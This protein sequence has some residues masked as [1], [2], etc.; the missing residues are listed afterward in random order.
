MIGRLAKELKGSAWRGGI[1]ASEKARF[2]R[3]YAKGRTTRAM[4]SAPDYIQKSKV[5]QFAAKRPISSAALVGVAGIGVAGNF[6]NSNA[7]K[8]NQNDWYLKRVRRHQQSSALTGLA[9]M[10]RSIGGMTG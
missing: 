10:A 4:A 8:R 6:H 9:P 3:G 5:A 7:S 2:A 1:R